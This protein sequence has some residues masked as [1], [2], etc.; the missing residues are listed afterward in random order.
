MYFHYYRSQR[1]CGKVMFLHLSVIL[2]TGGICHTPRADTPH[3]ETPPRQTPPIQYMLGYGQQAGGT[4][5]TGMQSCLNVLI[6]IFL[7][8][9][10]STWVKINV[11]VNKIHPLRKSEC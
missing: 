7:N 10:I 9:N 6:L 2:F 11:Y 1:C 4:H 8:S 3:G 5:P